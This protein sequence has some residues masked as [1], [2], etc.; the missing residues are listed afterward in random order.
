MN[1]S[2]RAQVAARA[3]HCCEYCGVPQAYD[4]IPFELDH[5]IARKHR[6]HTEFANL[7]WACFS[8]NNFKGPNI[9]GVDP[10]SGAVEQLYH[11]RTDGWNAHFEWQGS[12]LIGKTPKGRATVE[13]LE[14]NLS[15]RVAFRLELMDEGVFPPAM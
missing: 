7:A 3:K 10:A 15:Y 2:L 11:P 5:I 13:V 12:V 1:K 4:P 9:S 14:I 6:G 8:C